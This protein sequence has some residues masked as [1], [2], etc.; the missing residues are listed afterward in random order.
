L[1]VIGRHPVRCNGGN[2]LIAEV[3]DHELALP[4]PVGHGPE[5]DADLLRLTPNVFRTLI[6]IAFTSILNAR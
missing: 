1:L 6:V 4:G 5:V 3:D 2:W